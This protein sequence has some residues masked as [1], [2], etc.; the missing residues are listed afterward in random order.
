[1][2]ADY[3]D[4]E[5]E[6]VTG[7]FALVGSIEFISDYME[8]YRT[9]LLGLLSSS[10]NDDDLAPIRELREKQ[11][12]SFDAVIE[13]GLLWSWSHSLAGTP[14]RVPIPRVSSGD[15]LALAQVMRS[16]KSPAVKRSVAALTD[17]IHEQILARFPDSFFHPCTDFLRARFPNSSSEEFTCIFSPMIGDNGY[18]VRLADGSNIWNVG[19]IG[20]LDSD[21]Y[22]N[23]L[24]QSNNSS[25]LAYMTHELAHG[26]VSV[27]P[28]LENLDDY[29]ERQTIEEAAVLCLENQFCLVQGFFGQAEKVKHHAGS[30]GFGWIQ[31]CFDLLDQEPSTAWSELSD[32]LLAT[33][34][35]T[36]RGR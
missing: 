9:N 20:I 18:G 23:D 35:R 16:V 17:S 12:L 27:D 30:R 8:P 22:R 3:V 36:H 5:L 21:L 13:L 29:R 33:E 26:L 2:S 24:A 7:L 19:V 11:T 25:M 1:M 14:K 32:L 34:E 15:V 10:I 28:A 31:P 6:I 4:P